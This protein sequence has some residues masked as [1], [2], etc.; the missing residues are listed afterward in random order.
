MYRKLKSAAAV[1]HHFKINESSVRAIVKE[2]REAV[3][4]AT[5][6]GAKTLHFLRDAFFY[7]V[8]KMLLL[9]GC[10]IAM[11]KASL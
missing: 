7:L 11:R 2:I 6:A 9:C 5:P 3:E 10:R 4:A 8:L 1:A